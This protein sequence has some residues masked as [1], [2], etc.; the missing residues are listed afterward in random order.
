MLVE[1]SESGRN[2]PL[3]DDGVQCDADAAVEGEDAGEDAQG[4]HVAEV[5]IEGA[6]KAKTLW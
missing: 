6:S 1:M 5:M 4:M 2:T 3:Y